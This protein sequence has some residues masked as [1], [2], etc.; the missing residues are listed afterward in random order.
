MLLPNDWVNKAAELMPRVLM[1][2]RLPIMNL[3]FVVILDKVL[4]INY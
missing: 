4:I 1:T 3:V 2:L